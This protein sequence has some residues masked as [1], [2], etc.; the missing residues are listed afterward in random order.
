MNI[1]NATDISSL[2]TNR[3]ILQQSLKISFFMLSNVKSF[4]IFSK[5]NEYGFTSK[6]FAFT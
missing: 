1:F 4:E 2:I 3:E 6:S 5:H